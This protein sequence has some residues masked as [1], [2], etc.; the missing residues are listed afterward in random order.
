MKHTCITIH[1]AHTLDATAQHAH[2]HMHTHTCK[3]HTCTHTHAHITHAHTHM[4]TSN[5]HTHTCI[6]M[7]KCTQSHMHN[8]DLRNMSPFQSH[9]STHI[10]GTETIS[11]RGPHT[12]GH[13]TYN[14]RHTHIIA[15]TTHIRQWEHKHTCTI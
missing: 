4:H 6:D 2:T 1:I 8:N 15:F 9:M 14:K 7:Y 12:H 10:H 3:T 5:M 11:F 13:F